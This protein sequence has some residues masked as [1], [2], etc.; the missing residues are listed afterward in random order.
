MDGK[1]LIPSLKMPFDAILTANKTKDWLWSLDSSGPHSKQAHGV[2]LSA[3]IT[4]QFI[5]N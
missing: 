4:S 2:F 1:K 3:N 5:L